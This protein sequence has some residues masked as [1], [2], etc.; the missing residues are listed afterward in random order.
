MPRAAGNCSAPLTCPPEIIEAARAVPRLAV[1][2]TNN[3]ALDCG[4]GG[5]DRTVDAWRRSGLP[6]LGVRDRARHPLGAPPHAAHA[7]VVAES[8]DG[9]TRAGV[10]AVNHYS[11]ARYRNASESQYD[12]SRYEPI[13]N[14][15]NSRA[16]V[17]ALKEEHRLDASVRAC[18]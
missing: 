8:S 15:C 16:C 18:G 4:P 10:I 14:T 3:H 13:G 6:L 12:A 5:F 1:A 17:R 2:V 11:F 7:P 9:S